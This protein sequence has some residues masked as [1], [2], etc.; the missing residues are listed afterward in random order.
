MLITVTGWFE[1][2][3]IEKAK[4]KRLKNKTEKSVCKVS[5][6]KKKKKEYN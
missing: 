5:G 2:D 6:K 1:E 4:L 3:V